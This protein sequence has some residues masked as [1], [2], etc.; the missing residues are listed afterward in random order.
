MGMKEA[1]CP[2]Y[3]R[4]NPADTGGNGIQFH[5][6]K[7]DIGNRNPDGNLTDGTNK[8]KND[9]CDAIIKS[10]KYIR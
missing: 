10:R 5:M 9:F 2:E 4:G 6:G 7:Q 3:I 1:D 8:G